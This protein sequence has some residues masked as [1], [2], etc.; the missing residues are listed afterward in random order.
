MISGI[1]N[2]IA[3]LI[4]QIDGALGLLKKQDAKNTEHELISL[5]I[6]YILAQIANDTKKAKEIAGKITS[7]I[8]SYGHDMQKADHL[9]SEVNAV[10]KDPKDQTQ[11]ELSYLQGLL[12]LIQKDL[13][14][15]NMNNLP[16]NI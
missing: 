14:S 8:Q 16:S 1:S 7:L 5:L 13:P 6:Q 10:L 2:Q 12:S 3:N 4:G 9:M 11:Q 15:G